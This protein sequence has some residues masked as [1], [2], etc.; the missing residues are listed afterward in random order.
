MRSE[1][2]TRLR[3]LLFPKK[4]EELDEELRF[5][6]EQSIQAHV[7]AGLAPLEARRRAMVEFGGVEGTREQ[8]VRQRPGWFVDSICRD[9]LH[10]V[11]LL[12]RSPGL[13][14]VA[15]LTLALGIGANT[16]IF[17]LV[18]GI[19]LRP[20]PIADPAHLVALSS[21]KIHAA[22]NSETA[23]TGSSYPE[24]RDLRGSVAAFSD[25]AASDRRGLAVHT[26]DGL[27]L[28]LAAV[29]SD[30]YFSFLGVRP[31]LGRLPEESELGRLRAPVVVLSHG[32]WKRMFG[33]NPAVIGQAIHL[34]RG[35]SA[36]VV[37]VAPAGFRG[38]ERFID[39]QIYVPQSSWLI[40]NPEEISWRA[41]SR[42]DREFELYARLGPGASLEQ[43][44]AQLRFFSAKLAEAY[45]A[46]NVGRTLIADWQSKSNGEGMQLLG[47]L[48]LAIAGAVLLIACTNVANLL[49]ALNDARRREIA[50]RTALGATRGMLLRQLVTEYAVLAGL[51]VAGALLLAQRLI[52]LVPALLPDIG[53]PLGFDFR[54]DHRV[55]AFTAVAGLASVVVCGLIPALATTRTAPLEAMKK[56]SAR[57]GRLRMP[58]RKVFV[59]AQLATSMALLIVTGLLIKA[60]MQ[61]GKMDLGFDSRQNAVLM[62]IAVDGRAAQRLAEFDTLVT[63]M[64][65]LPGVKDAS[66]ARVVPFPD[67]GGGMTQIV[68]APDEPRSDTAGTPVWFNAIDNGYFRAMSI[69]LARGRAFAS[70]DTATSRRVVIVNQALAQKIFGSSDVVG[71]VLRLGREKPADA[72]IVGVTVNGK[73][74][75]LE[76]APQPYLYFP[77]C[78]QPLSEVTLIVTTAGD[79]GPLLPVVRRTLHD[80]SPDTLIINAQTLTD[81]MQ[82]VTYAN[83]MAAWLTA[84]LGGLALLL[85]MLG[86]YGITA[87]AVS[88]R[89]QEIGIRMALGAMRGTVFRSV[90]KDGMM[91]TLT[92]MLLG[93][94][95]ALVCGRGMSSLL[96][97]VKPLDPATLIAVALLVTATSIAALIIP[98]RRALGV[99]PVVALREE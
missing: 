8:C 24:Y 3:F 70:E 16:A 31:E 89:T 56:Q 92:G 93:M 17:S 37:A 95:A 65:A 88:R 19:S 58:A 29:V 14:S 26:A 36:T 60:W 1:I 15:V 32:T 76:E 96:F 40:L 80:A 90:V 25:V 45:P 10:G 98:A 57:R 28:L 79:A 84:S 91:L 39:P 18:D 73:Y 54:I 13:M 44:R 5:H 72:E 85:T 52:A 6:L 78:Q 67:S 20:L 38:T 30:N 94:G 63:R 87:F 53:Y 83:R 23:E 75:D 21:V 41:S 64:K 61:I 47:M 62:G 51:G 97:G 68:L 81:H 11:R 2:W 27:Q 7:E 46:S 9:V 4:Q 69:P 34:T 74:A 42:A 43:A 59:V 49:L 55:L 71:R 77:L 35:G 33:G 66:V 22:A 82:L 86:L 12:R 50:M 48:V 99:D